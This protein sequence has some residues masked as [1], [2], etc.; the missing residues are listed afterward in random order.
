M[1]SEFPDPDEEYE[2]R[3]AEEFELMNELGELLTNNIAYLKKMTII[4]LDFEENQAPILPK[5]N[6]FKVKK[7]LNFD[8]AASHGG[9][10]SSSSLS[11][12]TAVA[13]D[14]GRKRM[15]DQIFG[16]LSDDD[17]LCGQSIILRRKGE[18]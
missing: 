9:S 10:R 7:S 8:D 15:Q 18:C 1:A 4:L 11:G 14:V 2:M 6:D 12:Q 3:Y 13:D 17:E 16:S 5:G